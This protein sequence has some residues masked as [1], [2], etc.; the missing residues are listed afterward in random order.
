MQCLYLFPKLRYLITYSDININRLFNIAGYLGLKFF[1]GSDCL[2]NFEF[3]HF[4]REKWVFKKRL[5]IDI[6]RVI[7]KKLTI[8]MD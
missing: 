4:K 3:V 8:L 7:I 6:P 1:E 5:I 2:N